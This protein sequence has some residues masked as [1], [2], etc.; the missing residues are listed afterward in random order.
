VG[1]SAFVG[2]PPDAGTDRAVRYDVISPKPGVILD[3]T[4]LDP[5]ILGLLTHFVYSP[6]APRGRSRFCYWEEGRCEL[7]EKRMVQ[8]WQ[9][10]VGVWCHTLHRRIVLC[11]GKD[12]AR[13]LAQW[14]ENR[15]G[16]HMLKFRTRKPETGPKAALQFAE[17]KA[18]AAYV[19]P[20]LFDITPSVA[21]VLGAPVLPDYRY[22]A[23]ELGEQEVPNE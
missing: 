19:D 20:D 7:C 15:G 16:L 13:A 17:S 5:R 22:G 18:I 1:E 14:A 11:L 2:V 21:A 12:S 23:R 3:C 10:Y 9:G 8:I 6:E 4:C